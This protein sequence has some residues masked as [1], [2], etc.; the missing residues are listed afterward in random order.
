MSVMLQLSKSQ[1]RVRARAL[2]R[3]S[4]GATRRRASLPQAAALALIMPH[5]SHTLRIGSCILSWRRM[6]DAAYREVPRQRSQRD[7]GWEGTRP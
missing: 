2:S 1:R 6:V 7:T 4:A 3:R 5:K